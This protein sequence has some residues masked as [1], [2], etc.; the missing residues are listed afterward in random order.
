MCA[1][2]MGTDGTDGSG[3]GWGGCRR[4]GPSVD[5]IGFPGADFILLWLH[6]PRRVTVL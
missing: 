3:G 4:S 6:Q 5:I 1:L 2:V